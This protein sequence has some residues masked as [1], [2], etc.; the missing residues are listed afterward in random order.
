[1]ADQ[2]TQPQT[3]RKLF[4]DTVITELRGAIEEAKEQRKKRL[5][6]RE[7]IE[8]LK[9]ELQGM[10]RTGTT[11]DELVEL[12]AKKNI[13]VSV[14]MLRETLKVGKTKRRNGTRHRPTPAPSQT[15]VES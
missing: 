11:Y 15:P 14:P 10:L 4:E 8:Q 5:S 6:R 12:F 2:K 3:R 7:I 13:E 9:D 1:M